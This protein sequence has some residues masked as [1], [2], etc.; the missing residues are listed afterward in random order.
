MEEG[1]KGSTVRRLG[2]QQEADKSKLASI[3]KRFG[4]TWKQI[5][6][7]KDMMQFPILPTCMATEEVNK[8]ISLCESAYRGLDRCLE[9]GKS[10]ENPSTPYARM[11]VCKPHWIKFVKCTKRRDELVMRSVKTWERHYYSSLDAPSQAEYLEDLDTKKRYFLYALSRTDD[12]ARRD[13]FSLNAQHCAIRHA[14]LLRSR[15]GADQ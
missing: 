7:Y 3:E 14:S 4:F 9:M 5:H 2:K 12:D 15:S 8:D 6:S 11:Q 13:R 10:Y 1:T